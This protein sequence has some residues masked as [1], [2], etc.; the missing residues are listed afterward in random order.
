MRR[1]SCGVGR[2]CRQWH[3][4]C[5]RGFLFGGGGPAF[6]QEWREL[7]FDAL[8]QQSLRA[9]P[10]L[11]D[12]REQLPVAMQRYGEPRKRA[13][14]QLQLQCRHGKQW[15]CHANRQQS[16]FQPHPDLYLRSTQSHYLRGHE[17]HLRNL[18]LGLPIHVRCLSKS[19]LASGLVTELQ[20]LQ[21]SHHGIR[22]GERQQSNLRLYIRR[23]GQHPKRW[24]HRLLVQR[25]KSDE[26]RQRSDLCLRR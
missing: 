19:S 20:W 22:N 26:N 13:G 18:V 16:E 25:R 14:L 8:L 10:H 7:Y 21:R 12:H 6:A 17:R 23:L 11:G 2:G 24:H 15:R 4:L 1:G 3:Q 5:N 9:L